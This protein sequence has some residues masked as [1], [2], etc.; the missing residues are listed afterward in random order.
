M[1]VIDINDTECTMGIAY[2]LI[3]GK[4]KLVIMYLL[5]ED[6]YRFGELNRAIPGIR[7]GYL[8]Q[9]LRELEKDGLVNRKIY[10]QIPPKVEYSLTDIGREIESVIKAIGNWG[11][12][13]KDHI[14][15]KKGKL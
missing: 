6:T 13:Y 4:W 10:K 14:K 7:Q 12:L 8:T 3:Q 9:Q 1:K 5:L 15:I 2:N 11:Q